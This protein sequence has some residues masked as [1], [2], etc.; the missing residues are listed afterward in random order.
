VANTAQA[1]D[2]LVGGATIGGTGAGA[3]NLISGNGFA[4][5]D[6][7]YGNSTIVE[8]NR[9]GTDITGT[10]PLGNGGPGIDLGTYS[11]VS[12]D[13]IG[14]FGGG[15]IIAFNTGPGIA[16]TP[17]AVGN[18]LRFNAIFNNGGP[19]IDLNNDGVTPNTPNGPYNTP[20][21]SSTAGGI[22][23]GTLNAAPNSVYFIDFYANPIGDASP[24][25][26]Q[27]RDYVTSMEIETNAA[28]NAVF[29]VNATQFPGEPILTATATDADGT[30]SEFSLPLGF[31]LSAL[32]ATMAATAGVPFQGTVASFT[33]SDSSATTADFTAAINYGDGTGS[34]TGTVLKAPSG[35]V[36]VGIHTFSSPNATE[37][38]TVTITDTRGFGQATA[39]S[40]VDVV[41]PAGVLTPFGQGVEFVA[42]T[43]YTRTVAGFTDSSPQAFPGEFSAT[44]AWGDGT[45]SSIGVVS[46]SGA[47]FGVSGS[48]TYNGAGAYNVSVAVVDTAGVAAITAHSTAT[49]DPVPITIQAR[50]FAVTGKKNFSGT[51]ATFTDGDPRIDP[52]FYTATIYWAPGVTGT[53]G[54]ITGTNP[55]TVTGS[56][57]FPAFQNTQLVTIVITD[58]NGRAV[59]GVDRVV[60]PP[61]VLAIE[62][63]GLALSRNHRF[64]G[65]IATFTDSVP[66]DPTSAY[67][68][69][70]NWGRGRRSAGMIT[71]AN[72]QFV[73]SARHVFPR[74]AGTNQVTI[75]VTDAD[76]QSVSVSESASYKVSHPRPIKAAQRTKIA[77][78]R[79]QERA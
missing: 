19:G 70:I 27:G 11:R 52:T 61:E 47:G 56:H 21:L 66:T 48:H 28:G 16:T 58:K 43:L 73:V 25:R 36:V 50:N 22:I 32:G 69:T 18:S 26:P 30:T 67:K 15:N 41:S 31:A 64:Q 4:G 72:G 39:N 60:D 71:G 54:V 10:V 53:A 63:S 38:V 37:P 29:T 45:P 79:L 55:F 49:V 14:T 35:F 62:A 78:R 8:G 57:T 77:S 68:A 33:S 34:L 12:G 7:Q 5:I 75:T 59:S 44:I 24:A 23:S 74:F 20:I 13:T 17:E 76:G 2:V 40:L 42:G 1:V 51:V 65:L 6:I 46:S 3:G 9:I